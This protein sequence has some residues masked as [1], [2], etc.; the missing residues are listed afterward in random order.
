MAKMLV[1]SVFDAKVGAYAQPFFMRSRGEALRGWQDVANDASTQICKYSSDF[2]LMEIGE[3]D[4]STGQFTNTPTPLSLG[5]AAQ[6][7]RA[8]ADVTPLEA[9][10]AS[11]KV[12]SLEAREGGA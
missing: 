3:Y 6:F 1:F 11:K 5:T 10:I 8:P 9:M 12:E 7:K 2:S 4:D